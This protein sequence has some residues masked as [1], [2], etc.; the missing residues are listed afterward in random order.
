[1]C[2]KTS[3]SNTLFETTRT[4]ANKIGISSRCKE[5][6][7]C[8]TCQH[9]CMAMEI[10]KQVIALGYSKTAKKAKKSTMQCRTMQ[11]FVED[12]AKKIALARGYGCN[13]QDCCSK[14]SCAKV[15]G[16]IPF[17]IAECMIQAG[18]RKVD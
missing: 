10:A 3:I 1:M 13:S 15:V 11:G 4:I 9:D 17:D 16:C 5:N 7:N 2:S 6:D 18:Y 14:C 8:T 12:L